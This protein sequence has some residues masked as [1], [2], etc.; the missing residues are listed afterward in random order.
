MRMGVILERGESVFEYRER[1]REREKRKM[2]RENA[3]G[4][5]ISLW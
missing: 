2:K 3:F 1:E 5:Y 4:R